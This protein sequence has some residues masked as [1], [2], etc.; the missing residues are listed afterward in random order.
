MD[1]ASQ[2]DVAKTVTCHFV[3]QVKLEGWEAESVT[4]LDP[5]GR[6]FC[7]CVITPYSRWTLFVSF[8]F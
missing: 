1:V 5:F 4:V 6:L 7:D 8:A 2:C 3:P